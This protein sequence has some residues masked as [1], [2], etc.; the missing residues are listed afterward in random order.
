MIARESVD[1]VAPEG[2]PGLQLSICIATRNRASALA[3]TLADITAQATRECEIVVIDGGSTDGTEELLERHAERHGNLRYLR[4]SAPNGYERDF[5]RAMDHARGRYCWLM[6]DDDALAPDAIPRVLEALR[7]ERYSLVLVNFSIM[8]ATRA[9]IVR[10]RVAEL[11]EDRAY[12][13]DDLDRLFR[14]TAKQV[15]YVGSIVIQRSL[16]RERERERYHGSLHTH[17]A[18]VFQ[19]ALPAPAL[20]IAAPL[21]CHHMGNDHSWTS[22]VREMIFRWPSLVSSLAVSESAKRELIDWETPTLL[23]TALRIRA[24]DFLSPA[25]FRRWRDP[26]GRRIRGKAI[27]IGVSMIPG[28]LANLGCLLYYSVKPRELSSVILL[29]LRGSRFYVRNWPLIIACM[30]PRVRSSTFRL[31]WPLA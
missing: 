19:K 18:V 4:E 1:V 7:G 11:T 29:R 30:P 9:T 23:R 10:E 21:I 31:R 6:P 22:R 20:V 25:D 15:M 12:G 17:L 28:W 2:A 14:D 5:D 13:P 27:A 8:D 16:W 24:L 26:Y 3:K